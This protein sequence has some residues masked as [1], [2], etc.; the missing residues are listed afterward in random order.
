M[1]FEHYRASMDTVEDIER[2]SSTISRDKYIETLL[3]CI[4]ARHAAKTEPKL[5]SRLVA[6][7]ELGVLRLNSSVLGR[8]LDR[9]VEQELKYE[10]SRRVQS[11]NIDH[12]IQANSFGRE[13][14]VAI[15][16]SGKRVE[17]PERLR[18]AAAADEARRQRALAASRVPV[19]ARL[20]VAT[21]SLPKKETS[22][23]RIDFKRSA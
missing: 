13:S 14:S 20:P 2:K 18:T 5:L 17:Y 9:F 16:S 7:F 19:H 6:W 4:D 1:G 22:Q 21:M 10:E 23:R 15:D 12:L 8:Y 11:S 3:G